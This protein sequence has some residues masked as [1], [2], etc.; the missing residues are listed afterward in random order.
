MSRKVGWP[1]AGKKTVS[2]APARAQT[3]KITSST[4]V[5]TSS[6]PM[7]RLTPDRSASRSDGGCPRSSWALSTYSPVH[8]SGAMNTNP[9]TIE[10][11]NQ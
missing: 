10:S 2:I 4:S 5:K 7:Y 9:P 1:R 11:M 6:L 8:V 3:R